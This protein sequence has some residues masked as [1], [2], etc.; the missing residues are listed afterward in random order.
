MQ[1]DLQ[2]EKKKEKSTLSLHI[3]LLNLTTP[4]QPV[5]AEW[6]EGGVCWL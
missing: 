3:T 5:K 4:P 2:A 1:G 6:S